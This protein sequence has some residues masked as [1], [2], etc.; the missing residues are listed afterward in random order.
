LPSDVR[1]FIDTYI[2]SVEQLE[3]LLLLWSA[4]AEEWSAR[5]VS[6]TLRTCESSA[7]HR[8]ADL[9]VHGLLTTRSESPALYRYSSRGDSVDRTV[10]ALSA[11]YAE[12]RYRVID[13]IFAK[14]T[15]KLR[16]YADAFR[17]RKEDDGDG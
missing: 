14:P 13:A 7:A 6:D 4:P 3:I 1:R 11:V 16:V 5:R 8:L 10:A 2:S 15:D 17:I 12:F 9:A